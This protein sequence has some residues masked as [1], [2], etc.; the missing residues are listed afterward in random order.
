MQHPSPHSTSERLTMAAT[1]ARRDN[2]R[3]RLRTLGVLALAATL[4]AA[5]SSTNQGGGT[6][7][8]DKVLHL[9]FL[10]DPGQP[11]DPDIFYA[12]QGLLLTANTYEGLLT[13]QSGTNVATLAPGLATSWTASPDN[14]VFTFQLRQGVTFHDGTPFT[15]AAVKASF[16]RRRAVNQ[17]P[18]YMVSDITS[19]TTQGDY[20][21]TVTLNESNA[22]FLSYMASSYGPK[23]MS[24]TAL[25][26]N[27]GTDNAQNYLTTHD[28]GTGPYTLTEAKVGDHYKMDA[29]PKYWGDKPYFTTVDIPVIT[30]SSSQQLQFNNGQ[31][32]AIMHDIPSSAVASY[33]ANKSVSSYTLPAM[34]SEF[35]YV[36]PKSPTFGDVATRRA[37]LQAVD[38]DAIVKQ[39]YYGR[40]SKPT[41]IYPDLVLPRQF[42]PQNVAYDPSKLT[43]IVAGL[44][45]A[46]KTVTVGYDTS[47]PDAQIV[48]NLLSTQLNAV[49]MTTKVQGYPTAQIFGWVNDPDGAPDLLAEQN[50][51]DSPSPYTWGH[52]SWDP[53]AGINY[54]NCTDPATTASLA[55]GL[56]TG[57]NA[58]FDAAGDSALATGCWLNLADVTDFMVAQ[59]WLK[60]VEA[61]HV[62]SNP[63]TL[64]IAKLS[65]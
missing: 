55:K 42:A 41:Q 40:G 9:S 24:P 52:I 17:A 3:A 47:M 54:F 29:Y 12:S 36:N 33:I 32:A 2:L 64:M 50:W 57:D 59:P 4:V 56:T 20:S 53:K 34:I 14:K 31:L 58:D 61:A 44:P 8:T 5:C 45:A 49:G 48:A 65:A 60:G 13:Y 46:Q 18:A 35:L 23:M 6:A 26:A 30:D 19:V 16:D 27:A 1:T 7:P 43:S 51:P 22:A 10:Q 38:I 21:V 15:S 63:N 11:P 39:T 25:A 28:V 62:I 37:L